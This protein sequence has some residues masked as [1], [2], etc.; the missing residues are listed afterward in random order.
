MNLR[1]AFSPEA[2]AHL[3]ELEDYIEKSSGS[4]LTAER[5]IGR[6]LKTCHSLRTSPF[7]GTSRDDMGS[8]VRTTGFERRVTILFEVQKE[9]ILIL[10]IFYAGRKFEGSR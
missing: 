6:L 2:Q 1:V 5:Y 8:G 3:D 10:G 4:A 9:Q 7:R